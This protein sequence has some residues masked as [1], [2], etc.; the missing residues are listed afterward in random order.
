MRPPV[1]PARCLWRRFKQTVTIGLLNACTRSC[2]S[3]L[4]NA[5][6]VSQIAVH[7]NTL[8]RWVQARRRGRR[9][10]GHSPWLV[11]HDEQQHSAWLDADVRPLRSLRLGALN[12]TQDYTDSGMRKLLKRL[13][14]VQ[15]NANPQR[16]PEC[17]HN[18]IPLL[19][20]VQYVLGAYS[21]D[22]QS[23]ISLE[24]RESCDAERV[25][26]L[27]QKIRAANPGGTVHL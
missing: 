5:Q 4:Q 3:T 21:P 2:C 27:L 6:A 12:S 10:G 9:R 15:A 22:D 17:N 13:D 1:Q 19:S 26:Q 24:G 14:Y 18:I 25:A 11:D 23:L 20:R 7:T 8:K 16:D